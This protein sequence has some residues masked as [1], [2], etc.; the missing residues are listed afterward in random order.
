M[1]TAI[2][3]WELILQKD[4]EDITYSR[5]VLIEMLNDFKFASLNPERVIAFANYFHKEK[6]LMRRT[7][8]MS[9]GS[10][11]NP[12]ELYQKFFSDLCSGSQ[13]KEQGE[14]TK[15]IPEDV[16]EKW[17][18]NTANKD[19]VTDFYDNTIYG[20]IIGAKAMQS[21]EIARWAKENGN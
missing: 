20:K 6:E 8:Q 13:E 4:S 15:D 9:N 3:K 10:I 19:D 21:G 2:N 7:G 18:Y 12:Q 1:K 11:M 14:P 16:I 17:A 5:R